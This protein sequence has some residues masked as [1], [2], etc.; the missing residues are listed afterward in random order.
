MKTD[1]CQTRVTCCVYNLYSFVQEGTSLHFAYTTAISLQL[2]LLL[3][4]T[5][6]SF[7]FSLFWL[8]CEKY[9][10]ANVCI[11]NCMIGVC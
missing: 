9:F 2:I 6:F 10:E 1:T 7:E 5:S 11:L 3:P 8:C 4:S